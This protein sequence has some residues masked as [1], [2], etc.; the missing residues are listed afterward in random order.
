LRIRGWIGTSWFFPSTFTNQDSRYRFEGNLPDN[1]HM[2]ISADGYRTIGVN[3]YH[4]NG[5]AEGTF[6]IMMQ[7]D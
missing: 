7:L 4:P 2:P 3:S 1:I 5:Q 6:D